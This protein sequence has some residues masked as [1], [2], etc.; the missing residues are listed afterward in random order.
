VYIIRHDDSERIRNNPVRLLN[1]EPACR[2]HVLRWTV[3]HEETNEAYGKYKRKSV[4]IAV[5]SRLNIV[6]YGK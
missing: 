3:F 4:A 1:G 2:Q 6:R 5:A